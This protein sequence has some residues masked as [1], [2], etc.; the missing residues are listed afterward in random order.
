MIFLMRADKSKYK[1]LWN[2]LRIHMTQGDD[3]YPHDISS[4]RNI[5]YDYSMLNSNKNTND[6]QIILSQVN[7]DDSESRD[8]DAL[9]PGTDG[10]CNPIVTCYKCNKK[11]HIRHMCPSSDSPSS[12][13]V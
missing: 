5:L 4:A 12:D 3:R 13:S 1:H 9:I 8:N 6:T 7:S 2:D 11:G 10:K